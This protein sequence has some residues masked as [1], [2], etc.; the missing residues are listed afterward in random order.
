M[1]KHPN[2]QIKGSY[3]A[4]HKPGKLQ[5]AKKPHIPAHHDAR[6]RMKMSKGR[7]QGGETFPALRGEMEIVSQRT[8]HGNML[9][10]PKRQ[11]QSIAETLGCDIRLPQEL[12]KYTPRSYKKTY[13]SKNAKIKTYSSAQIKDIAP[14]REGAPTAVWVKRKKHT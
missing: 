8:P 6:E 5:T 13:Q 14:Y 3:A 4:K 1:A 9:R 2:I 12:T 11:N 7:R 10:M